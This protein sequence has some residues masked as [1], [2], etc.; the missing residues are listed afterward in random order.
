LPLLVLFVYLFN[1]SLPFPVYNML[2]VL[3]VALG[4]VFA[5][6]GLKLIVGTL[7][8]VIPLSMELPIGLGDS[9]ILFP[10][11]AIALV[12]LVAFFVRVFFLQKFKSRFL[13]HPVTVIIIFYVAVLFATTFT[14]TMFVV[15]AKF[16]FINVMY[17]SVF[18]FLANLYL[19]NK[20]NQRLS[21][22]FLYGISLFFVICFALYKHAGYDF[23]K[24]YVNLSMRPF[25][26]D[27]AIYS[28]CIAMLLPIF[29]AFA[30]KG[31]LLG[32]GKLAQTAAW[33]I[34]IALVV[35][36]VFSYSRAAWVSLAAAFAIFVLLLLKLKPVYFVLLFL[37]G[38][39]F[40]LSQRDSLISGWKLNRSNSSVSNPTIEEQ[41]KSIT[42]ISNDVSNAER[43]NRWSCAY[44]MFLDRPFT[45]FGP[46]TYQFQYLKYQIPSEMTRISVT[47]AYN[48]PLGKGGSAHSEY[49]LA[50]SESGIMGFLGILGIVLSSI[51]YGMVA[52]YRASGGKDKIIILASLLGIITYGVHVF[53]NNYLNIDKTASLFWILISI[54]VTIDSSRKDKPLTYGA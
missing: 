1:V 4:I 40:F 53:F 47:T 49:L 24:G 32:L 31:K 17:I 22:A 5:F 33:F 48:N 28:A 2:A 35:G 7:F 43:L 14:S 23:T 18:Y 26:S 27:H 9:K 16:A 29:A 13:K 46:G 20:A 34:S 52:Y 30:I 37:V 12:L 45:G 36:I 38:A 39:A 11:E 21:P 3:L 8:F 42:N 6:G 44:R 15:S 50:L 51:F 10:S 25:Y 19:R 41:T 54:L